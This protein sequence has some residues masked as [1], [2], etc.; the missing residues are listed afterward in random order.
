MGPKKHK[1][2]EKCPFYNRGYCRNEENC[3]Q[4]HPDKVCQSS[5]CFD[6]K[7]QF[8]HP[9]PCK[10]GFRCKFNV[11][12]LCLFSHVTLATDDKKIEEL[13]KRINQTEKEN[14]ALVS[15]NN[16]LAK[17]IENKFKTFD[18]KIELLRKTIETK[19]NEASLMEIKINNLET[20]FGEKLAKLEKQVSLKDNKF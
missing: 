11:K 5:D 1:K 8:R 6:D 17:Q 15:S 14:K 9:N 19:E 4:D 3:A 13:K 2:S 12:K 20:S 18:S 16:E 7:C 10:F